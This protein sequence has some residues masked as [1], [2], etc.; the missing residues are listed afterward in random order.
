[1]K[2]ITKDGKKYLREDEDTSKESYEDELMKLEQE[3]ESEL[4]ELQRL[5]DALK[6]VKDKLK[7]FN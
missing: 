6:E 2:I 3:K 4:I 1:M 7:L 5:E